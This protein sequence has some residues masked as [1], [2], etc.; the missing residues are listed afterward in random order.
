MAVRKFVALL[1]LA[2]GLNH[3]GSP[4]PSSISGPACTTLTRPALRLG[5]RSTWPCVLLAPIVDTAGGCRS[6]RERNML[7][8]LVAPDTAPRNLR[9]LVLPPPSRSAA[10]SPPP[11]TAASPPAALI[12]W[13]RVSR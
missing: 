6:G 4:H 5:A 7:A 13:R 10:T 9:S 3:A 1:S 8:G 11:P 2:T 12:N